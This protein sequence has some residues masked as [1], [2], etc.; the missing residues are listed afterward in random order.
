M[1]VIVVVPDAEEVAATYFGAGR[2]TQG[3]RPR[4]AISVGSDQ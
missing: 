3:T 2:E 4:L 1:I